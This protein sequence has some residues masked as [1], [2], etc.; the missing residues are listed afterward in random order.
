MTSAAGVAPGGRRD[1][2]ERA[3][4]LLYEAEAKSAHVSSV[5]AGQALP[6]DPYAVTLAG[7]VDG[8]RDELD[9][10]IA[11]RS[12]DWPIDRMPALDLTVLRIATYELLCEPEVPTEVVLAEATGLAGEYGTDDSAR[13]VNGVLAAIARDIRGHRSGGAGTRE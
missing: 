4:H 9:G 7:G 13:F 10:L 3:I 2:R 5:V 6:P 8:R 1:A 11:A 12:V